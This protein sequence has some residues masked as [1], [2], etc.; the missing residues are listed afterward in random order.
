MKRTA[1]SILA[2][3]SSFAAIPLAAQDMLPVSEQYKVRFEY[4]RFSPEVTGV[5][6]SGFDEA[7]GSSIDL[8][9]DLG[10]LKQ[11]TWSGHGVIKLT[12]GLK[13]RG[14]YTKIDLDGDATTDRDLDFQGTRFPAG[15]QLVT[16]VKGAYWTGDLE[17]DFVK[18]PWGYF[19]AMVGARLFD[20]DAVL[21]AVETAQREQRTLNTPVPSIGAV[22]RVYADR[23]SLSGEASGLT[24]GDRG[25]ILE[26]EG[27]A[28]VNVSDR[29][30][31]SGGYRYVK[32]KGED[33][34]DLVDAK[35]RG[36]TYGIEISL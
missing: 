11:K 20:V 16:S 13:L 36:W 17:F 19:G 18:G 6:Q 15:V 8:E 26:L 33:G 10:F 14:S 9:Q 28:R 30:A 27:M 31:I 12:P 4:R 25:T 24:L 34:L 21:V 29:M 23:F 32:V 35:L 3:A 22:L 5:V 2:I 7:P 1:F